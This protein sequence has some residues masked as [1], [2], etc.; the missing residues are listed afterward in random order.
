MTFLFLILTLSIAL[1]YFGLRKTAVAMLIVSFFFSYAL[2]W[3]Q[4]TS[5]LRINW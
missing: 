3:T 2:L 4:M 5:T 1:A